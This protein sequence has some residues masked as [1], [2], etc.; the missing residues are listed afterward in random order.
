MVCGFRLSRYPVNHVTKC[1][2]DLDLCLNVSHRYK[3]GEKN[4]ISKYATMSLQT[5]YSIIALINGQDKRR[6]LFGSN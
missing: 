4:R 5:N 1:H 6:L 3:V 2:A